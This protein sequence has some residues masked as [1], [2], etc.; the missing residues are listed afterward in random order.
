MEVANGNG[1]ATKGKTIA[2]VTPAYE[3]DTYDYIKCD[4][5]DPAAWTTATFITDG[6]VIWDDTATNDPVVC[7]LDFGGDKSVT[8]GTLTVVFDAHGVFRFKV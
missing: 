6:S 3:S 2:Q 1:Y 5:A 4:S 8:A 7:W